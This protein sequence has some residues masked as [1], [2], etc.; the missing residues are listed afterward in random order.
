MVDFINEVEEELRKDDYNRLL[1]KYG[2]AIGIV[3]FLIIAGTGFLEYKK[4]AADKIDHV[5]VLE[6]AARKAPYKFSRT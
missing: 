2:P 6:S 5:S 4:Y 3:L 1:K